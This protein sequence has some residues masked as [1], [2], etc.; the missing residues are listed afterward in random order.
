MKITKRQLRKIIR[1]GLLKETDTGSLKTDKDGNEYPTNYEGFAIE[2]KPDGTWL[3]WRYDHGRPYRYPN[4]PTKES[5]FKV[6]DR[7]VKRAMGYQGD[8]A[9]G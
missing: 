2:Q 3:G 4:H 6:I 8:D 5:L 7:H 9:E 1:E